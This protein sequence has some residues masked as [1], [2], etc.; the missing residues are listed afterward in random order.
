MVRQ[1]KSQFDV[2]ALLDD[3]SD[4]LSSAGELANARAAKVI[5]VRADQHTALDLHS[6]WTLFNAAWDFVVQSE[7]ICRRMIV[8]LRG[9]VVGQ[10]RHISIFRVIVLKPFTVENIPANVPSSTPLAICKTR[11]RRTMESRGSSSGYP[12]SRQSTCR[13]FL[14]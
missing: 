4:I 5:T 12:A 6:F 7:V 13:R 8:G 14:P 2:T 1:P 10:V 9:V 11:R 3:L